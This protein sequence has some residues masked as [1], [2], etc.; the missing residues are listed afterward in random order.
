[1]SGEAINACYPLGPLYLVP[2]ERKGKPRHEHLK[3]FK[4][5]AL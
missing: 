1:M 5:P 2:A 3:K 4:F